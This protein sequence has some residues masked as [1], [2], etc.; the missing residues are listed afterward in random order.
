MV[1]SRA[2]LKY[3]PLALA[4]PLQEHRLGSP[5]PSLCHRV[6]RKHWW[7]PQA[8]RGRAA[9]KDSNFESESHAKGPSSWREGPS[10]YAEVAQATEKSQRQ[11]GG[12]GLAK[13]RIERRRCHLPLLPRALR[14]SGQAPTGS[15]SRAR[16]SSC[17]T[18][19][20]TGG[21]DSESAAKTARGSIP[22]WVGPGAPLA[23]LLLPVPVGH[24]WYRAVT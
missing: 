5:T 9:S 12:P 13:A 10:R 6:H 22:S 18:Q 14:P 8:E 17:C 19:C 2:E 3:L 1:S 16:N 23:R 7:Q 21:S 20:S 15:C 11:C 4:P 24:G